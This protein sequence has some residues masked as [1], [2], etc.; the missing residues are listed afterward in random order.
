MI[1]ESALQRFLTAQKIDIHQRK[2]ELF[3]NENLN[4]IQQWEILKKDEDKGITKVSFV[5]SLEYILI[6]HLIKFQASLKRF[7]FEEQLEA[8][9]SVRNESKAA[10]LLKAVFSAITVPHFIQSNFGKTEFFEYCLQNTFAQNVKCQIDISDPKLCPITSVEEW[11]FFKSMN[12]LKTPIEKD[13]FEVEENEKGEKRF[14]I[15][16]RALESI[17]LPFKFE[18]FEN[19]DEER[20]YEIKV[21]Q[22]IPRM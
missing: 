22:N 15:H 11:R 13:L 3:S 2:E 19:E 14:F 16:L 4:R 12:N 21:S 1:H 10:K 8:Y 17:Y 6:K 20:S 18:N 9:K 7:I 5:L